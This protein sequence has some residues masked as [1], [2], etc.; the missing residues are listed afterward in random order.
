MK[1]L[2]IVLAAIGGLVMLGAGGCLAMLGFGAV[3]ASEAMDDM[4]NED[5]TFSMPTLGKE[6]VITLEEFEQL[7]DGISYARACEIIGAR[8]SSQSRSTMPGV[9][10]IAQAM[11]IEQFSWMNPGGSNASIQFQNDR[12]TM[13]SQFGLPRAK[14]LASAASK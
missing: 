14:T 5:G 3:A 9:E 4:T 1:T 6:P 7:A 8:G 2:L 13:K 10:G 11:T 12:L